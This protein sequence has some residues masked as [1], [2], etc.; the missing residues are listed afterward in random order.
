MLIS[1]MAGSTLRQKSASKTRSIPSAIFGTGSTPITTIFTCPRP[2]H[3]AGAATK[4]V[5]RGEV[6]IHSIET[7]G[8]AAGKKRQVYL[9]QPPTDEP[10]P[11]LVVY[12]G[13]DF[14]HRGK[15]AVIVDNL[16]AQKR[17]PPV[18]MALVQNGKDA[19]TIQYAC[20]ELTLGFVA[21]KVV[22][23][24]GEHLNLLD[25]KG[26]SRRV[27]RDGRFD[28]RVDGGIHRLAPAANVWQGAQPVR[29]VQFSA[30]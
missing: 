8:M 15:L 22:K 9:Y 6:T 13:P 3:A 12:D 2:L 16:I 17:I 10:A 11:L 19:R 26:K 14:L 1:N 30:A 5:P 18:A 20:S 25:F 28:G 27:R 29:R 23:L 4:G 21:E 24:A 7:D